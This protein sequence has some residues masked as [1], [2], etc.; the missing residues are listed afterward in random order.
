V[1]ITSE[2]DGTIAVLDLAA[3]HI[4]S[5]FVLLGAVKFETLETIPLGKSGVIKPMAVL[6]SF[7]ATRLNVSTG[8]WQQVFKVDTA[9]Q[10]I[11][12]SVTVGK[13]PW[14]IALT[15]DAK[16]LYSATGRQI[17]FR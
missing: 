11:L 14:G 4:I 13:R 6:L 8:R 10:T 3:G 7:D 16:T 17:T 9:T 5:T 15:P 12:G 1:L 2:E